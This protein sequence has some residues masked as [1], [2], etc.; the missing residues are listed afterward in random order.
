[1]VPEYGFSTKAIHSGQQPEPSTGAIMTPIYATSTFVQPS[2]G[3]NK[4][5]EYSR[6]G[7]PTRKALE[8]CI[9]DL[10]DGAQGYA[11][12][13]G[14]AASATILELLDA[15][16]H[17]IV[18][19]DI[20]GG[21]YRLLER[22]RK[23]SAGI[24]NTSVDMTDLG[25]F[26]NA[27]RK[28]TRLV[29]VESPSN[30]LLKIVDLEAIASIAREQGILSVCDNTF[31]TPYLQKP[32]TLGFDIVVHSATKYLNGHSDLVAGVAVVG[33]KGALADRLGFLQ[34][35]VGSVLSPFDSFLVLRGLKT[36]A[37]RMEAHAR[38]ATAIAEFLQSHPR[39][40]KVLYPGLTTHPQ[41]ALA[42][43]QMRQP[44]GMITFFLKGGLDESKRFLEKCKLFSLAESLG[45]VESLIEHPAI[46]THSSIPKENRERLGISDN[47]I[48]VSVGIEDV[49]DLIGDLSQALQ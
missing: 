28:E 4:G 47:L 48:R 29:W 10:E 22:V 32:L 46:M 5:F 20:Y 24:H 27:I 39:V 18:M 43:K 9:A 12:A 33:E 35:A 17:V 15:G 7:N 2:P 36:L 34:N 30:P 31:A 49:A 38:N 45:G 41:F 16:S 1:M 42:Q 23:I 14:L 19:D 6:S 26:R 25:A 44:G 21:S 37:L 40:E 3:V 8:T 11:F 13:S